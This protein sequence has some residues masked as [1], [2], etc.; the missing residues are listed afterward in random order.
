MVD[1]QKHPPVN[2]PMLINGRLSPIWHRWFQNLKI[3][4]DEIRRRPYRTYTTD[5]NLTSVELGRTLVFDIGT[6]RVVCTLPSVGPNDIYS[7]IT[8]VRQGTGELVIRANDSDKIER[9]GNAVSS[10]EPNRI[11][12]NVTLQ[13]VTQTQWAIIGSTGIWH[14][15]PYI[16]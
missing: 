2:E 12:A 10:S 5:Q 7:W 13:L 8:I 4:D 16:I 11:A 9:N 14:V 3:K 15:L 1:I 6:D